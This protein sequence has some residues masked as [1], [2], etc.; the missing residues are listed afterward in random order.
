M[1]NVLFVTL[2]FSI[3]PLSV[4][5][6]SLCSDP[7]FP[8]IQ[9]E[10]NKQAQGG[11]VIK[12]EE[13]LFARLGYESVE[14]PLIN[15]ARC[16]HQAEYGFEDGVVMLFRKPEREKYLIFSDPI[17]TTKLVVL[18]SPKYF[19]NGIDWQDTETFE[20]KI[21]GI[22]RG[23]SYGT[24]FDV[25]KQQGKYHVFETKD[26][27]SSLQMLLH[28]RID[29]VIMNE[30]VANLLITKHD[31]TGFIVTH[32]QP[33]LQQNQYIGISKLSPLANRMDE[34]NRELKKMRNEG[35]MKPSVFTVSQ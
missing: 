23:N 32:P 25:E 18:Y 3:F 8:Y 33:Y 19:S 17:M 1:R 15:W 31:F 26:E 30:V 12:F 2:L 7:W 14:F 22:V 29:M 16:L 24:K 5:A 27:I 35:E 21:I 6:I 34:I 4:G 20:S 9:G 11:D 28:G 13:Q 10:L